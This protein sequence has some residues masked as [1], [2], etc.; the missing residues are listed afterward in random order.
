MPRLR[1]VNQWPNF[2]KQ[3]RERNISI[4]GL[5]GLAALAV[6]IHHGLLVLAVNGIDNLWMQ[7]LYARLGLEALIVQILLWLTNGSFFVM[8]FM[9][10]SGWASSVSYSPNNGLYSYYTRRLSRLMPVYVVTTLLLYIAVVSGLAPVAI[11]DASLWWNWWL[12]G[13]ISLRELF[14]HLVF[15]TPGLGG[16]TWTMSVFVVGALV[17]PLLHKFKDKISGWIYSLLFVDLILLAW[18]TGKDEYLLFGAFVLGT[19]IN[20][21]SPSLAWIYEKLSGYSLSFATI[22][23]MCLRY[24]IFVRW[25][26]IVEAIWAFVLVGSVIYNKLPVYQN[27]PLIYLGKISYSYYLW[28]FLILYSVTPIL[29]QLLGGG[30]MALLI[31][32]L[33]S[34]LITIPV[35]HLSYLF[36][37][38]SRLRGKKS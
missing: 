33:V 34:V 16:A 19:T 7:P 11:P 35:A 28:H 20:R 26:W 13:P 38:Q 10:I 18:I 5:R 12:Q 25:I 3:S 15:L 21:C 17:Y 30:V 2:M 23:V 24:L 1:R 37:E 32:T 31:N 4:D 9:V 36:I 29:V 27:K 22:L 8:V 6:A 14:E